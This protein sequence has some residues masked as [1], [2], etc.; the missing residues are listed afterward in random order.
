MKNPMPHVIMLPHEIFAWELKDRAP[1]M[2]NTNNHM[3][4]YIPPPPKQFNLKLASL[5]TFSP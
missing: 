4:A 2:S 1:N 5:S 3:I